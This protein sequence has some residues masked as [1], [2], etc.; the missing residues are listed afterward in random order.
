MCITTCSQYAVQAMGSIHSEAEVQL[1]VGKHASFAA[2]LCT[3]P[4]PTYH[5][6]FHRFQSTHFRDSVDNSKPMVALDAWSDDGIEKYNKIYDLVEIDHQLRGDSF[7][8]ELLK[9]HQKRHQ[10]NKKTT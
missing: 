5:C 9:V 1:P 7:N 10:E 8:Q 3:K 4:T 2:D 6:Y